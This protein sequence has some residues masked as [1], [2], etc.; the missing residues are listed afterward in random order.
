MASWRAIPTL[1]AALAVGAA[2][3]PAQADVISD[4]NQT[5]CDTVAKIGPGAPGHR[6]L[7]V[8]QLAVFEA[9]NSIEPRYTPWMPRMTAPPGA[10]VDAAVAAANRATLL[11]LMPAE[12]PAIEAAYLAAPSARPRPTALP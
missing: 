4:W 5:A 3:A 11:A 10:S 1:L 2:M 9:V 8:V 7:A 12:K 6:M